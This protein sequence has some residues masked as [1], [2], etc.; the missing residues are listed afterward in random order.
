MTLLTNKF[1]Y[2]SL[3]RETIDGKRLYTCPSGQK[4][5][6]VTTVLSNTQ[7]VEKIIALEN[8]R[9]AVG[10][11]K[12]QEI[13]TM[14]ANRG[15]RM[16]KYIEEYIITGELKNPGSN[17]YSKQSHQMATQIINNGLKNVNEFWGV[18]VSLYFPGLY[19]GSTDLVGVHNGKESIMDHKQ[20]NKV[21]T[22]KDIEDYKIQ[23]AFYS[24]AHNEV[25]GTNIKKGVIFM[26][27]QDYQYLEFILE[28]REF[29]KYTNVVW[30][31]LEQYYTKN[32]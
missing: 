21:K 16:H 29:D 1:N 23:L 14:A 18:E 12:A 22:N 24:A 27:T 10:Y 30:D 2:T 26:C 17:P 3:T 20:S 28:G 8:W 31:R 25:Y 4:L 15:T 6:S 5:P 32:G 7:P 13:T 19:A 11:A 9:K